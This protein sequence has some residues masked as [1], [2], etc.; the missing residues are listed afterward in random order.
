MIV[1]HVS[2]VPFEKIATSAK[3]PLWFQLYPQ[4]RAGR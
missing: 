3:G 1:S 4:T 2:S